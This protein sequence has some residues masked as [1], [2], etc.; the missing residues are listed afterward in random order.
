[1][2]NKMEGGINKKNISEILK[3]F[4]KDHNLKFKEV[5]KD[6]VEIE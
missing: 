4:K 5:L 1:M 6:C 3:N 2:P